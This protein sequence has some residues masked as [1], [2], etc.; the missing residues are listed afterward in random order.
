M[1]I[2][3]YI[4]TFVCY[5]VILSCVGKGAWQTR[6]LAHAREGAE[7]LELSRPAVQRSR[8]LEVPLTSKGGSQSIRWCGTALNPRSKVFSKGLHARQRPPPH[9][10]W[11]ETRNQKRFPN[12]LR[13]WLLW[14]G[15]RVRRGALVPS[16]LAPI[17]QKKISRERLWCQQSICETSNVL[18]PHENWHA[19]FNTSIARWVCSL[20]VCVCARPGASSP[21]ARVCLWNIYTYTH[22]A[23][24]DPHDFLSCRYFKGW[25]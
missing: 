14:W 16:F 21:A 7:I 23:T 15:M 13:L 6:I 3:V 8:W 25:E 22:A 5:T 4:Y 1:H 20:Y 19:E 10:V 17:L 2:H 12:S 11:P 24:V 18:C 9:I